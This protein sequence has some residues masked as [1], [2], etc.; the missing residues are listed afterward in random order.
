MSLEFH[1]IEISR[2]CFVVAVKL[3]HYHTFQ[4]LADGFFEEER[5]RFGVP[6]NMIAGE[7]ENV[8]RLNGFFENLH[9]FY[10]RF[11]KERRAVFVQDVEHKGFKWHFLSHGFDVFFS[12]SSACFLERQEF[13]RCWMVGEGFCVQNDA[14]GWYLLAGSFKNFWK[15]L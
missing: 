9:A 10:Q 8:I 13:F 7:H 12:S 14:V 5:E 3:F 2:A 15:H 4:S 11:L 6:H 1:P